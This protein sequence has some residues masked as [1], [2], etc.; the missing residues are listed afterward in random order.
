MLQMRK[1]T[2]A[3]DEAIGSAAEQSRQLRMLEDRI[4]VWKYELDS[5]KWK[6]ST[7]CD[8]KLVSRKVADAK[9]DMDSLVDGLRLDTSNSYARIQHSVDKSFVEESKCQ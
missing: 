2:K 1:V 8:M 5:L 7:S 9:D 3:C 4:G 6:K